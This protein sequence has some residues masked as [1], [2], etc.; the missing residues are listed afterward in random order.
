[1]FC[2]K[3]N[4]RQ[5]RILVTCILVAGVLCFPVSF[6]APGS[7]HTRGFFA[8]AGTGLVLVGIVQAIRL[9]RLCR[10][11]EKLREYEV[12]RNEERTQFITDKAVKMVFFISVIAEYLGGITALLLG[13]SLLGMV[14]CWQVVAQVALMLILRG[15]YGKKY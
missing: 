6:F 14:L 7:D 15:V 2:K 11:P 12:S 9:W 3:F 8:G 1:M 4:V 10:D 13:Q 5:Q